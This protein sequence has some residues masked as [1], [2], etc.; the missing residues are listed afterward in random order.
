MD[1]V[2]GLILGDFLS[3][4]AWQGWVLLC[5]VTWE[6]IYAGYAPSRLVEEL[7]GIEGVFGSFE[8][9]SALRQ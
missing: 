3:G 8:A 1:R 6:G 2:S 4:D 5:M 7:G 9:Y